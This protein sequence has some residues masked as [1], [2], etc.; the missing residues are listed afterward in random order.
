MSIFIVRFAILVLPDQSVAN[1]VI[2]TSFVLLSAADTVIFRLKLL[3]LAVLSERSVSKSPV[4][5][6]VPAL[7]TV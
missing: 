5:V 7:V 6:S 1:T 2:T 3:V 4:C